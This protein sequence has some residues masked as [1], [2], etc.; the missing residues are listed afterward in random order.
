VGV[1]SALPA[2]LFAQTKPPDQVLIEM[3]SPQGKSLGTAQVP[4]VS[5]TIAEWRAQLSPLAFAVTREAATERPFSGTY[6]HYYA[7]GL[8]HC[9]C[10]ATVVFDSHTK[11]DSGTGWPSFWSAISHHN[12]TELGD[13]SLGMQ[14]TAVQCKRC[15]AHLGHVFDDGPRPTGLR[16]C[17]N[18]VA[19]QFVAFA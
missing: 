11:F 9:I 3:Y 13:D 12:I 2:G 8:Y 17:M 19:L 14:R 1:A 4:R 5:K 18:S 10:C 16:Y 6:D 15:D 7:A